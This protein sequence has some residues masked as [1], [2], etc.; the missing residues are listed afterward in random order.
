MY[1]TKATIKSLLRLY[2][3][4]VRSNHA[5]QASYYTEEIIEEHLQEERIARVAKKINSTKSSPAAKIEK[6][7]DNRRI[8]LRVSTPIPV[9]RHITSTPTSVDTYIPTFNPACDII[10][11]EGDTSSRSIPVINDDRAIHSDNGIGYER[12]GNIIL[13]GTS[14]PIDDTNDK[15]G[16][17]NDDSDIGADN[18][19]LRVNDTATAPNNSDYSQDIYHSERIESAIHTIVSNHQDKPNLIPCTHLH[20]LVHCIHVVNLFSLSSISLWNLHARFTLLQKLHPNESPPPDPPPPEP[21][22]CHTL[23]KNTLIHLDS[24]L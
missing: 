20:H 12:L 21:P 15:D 11:N 4:S 3:K 9:K 10:R 19:E 6:R 18:G 23:N 8:L 13:S 17:I 22:P 24:I 1:H 16:A 14:I 7:L 2:V 5:N